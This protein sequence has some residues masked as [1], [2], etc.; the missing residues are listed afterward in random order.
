MELINLIYR[1]KNLKSFFVFLLKWRN[2][3]WRS[4]VSTNY[5]KVGNCRR[6]LLFF[7]F[8]RFFQKKQKNNSEQE[9]AISCKYNACELQSDFWVFFPETFLTT[10]A[11]NGHR[12]VLSI[13]DRKSFKTLFSINV[14]AKIKFQNCFHGKLIWFT[15]NFLF[16]SLFLL[17]PFFSSQAGDSMAAIVNWKTRKRFEITFY[18]QSIM[19]F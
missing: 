11:W 16:P 8:I 12:N 17:F 1:R 5:F 3:L 7:S 6:L 9:L 10:L 15:C 4:N 14:A 13:F 2:V 19:Q 18:M